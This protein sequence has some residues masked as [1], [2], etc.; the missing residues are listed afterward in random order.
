MSTTFV[1]DGAIDVAVSDIWPV[2]PV[3]LTLY[4]KFTVD[5]APSAT[6]TLAIGS[7]HVTTPLQLRSNEKRMDPEF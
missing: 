5:D 2:V 3:R 6:D 1:C 7:L 4:G